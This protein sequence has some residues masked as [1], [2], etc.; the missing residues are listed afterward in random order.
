MSEKSETKHTPGPWRAS[1]DRLSGN[2]GIVGD[3]MWFAK[4]SWTVRDDRNEADAR[5]I[6]AAPELLDAANLAMEGIEVVDLLVASIEK[7]GNYSVESTLVFL[8][9]ARCAKLRLSEA[10]ATALVSEPSQS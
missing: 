2:H 5:L 8:N 4:I 9:Q 6:A 1:R 7:H 10:I 3:G